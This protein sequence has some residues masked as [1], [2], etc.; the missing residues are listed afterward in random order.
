MILS[1]N[2][3]CLYRENQKRLGFQAKIATAQQK[4]A[5][6][7]SKINPSR[8]FARVLKPELRLRTSEIRRFGV[9]SVRC[10]IWRGI[11]GRLG[12]K[13][14]K[15]RLPAFGNPSFIE[16][17]RQFSRRETEIQR[18]H[19]CGRFGGRSICFLGKKIASDAGDACDLRLRNF[20]VF[21]KILP[22]SQ[23]STQKIIS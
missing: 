9:E 2:N 11:E 6:N 15:L 22:R 21:S 8:D 4:E 17:C 1:S 7:R 12:R 19:F 18:N 10:E 14:G 3:Q 13:S 20:S 23:K 5:Q 16:V